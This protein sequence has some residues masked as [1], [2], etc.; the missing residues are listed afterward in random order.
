MRTR[1]LDQVVGAFLAETR[2]QGPRQIISLGA[3]TDTRPFRA[4]EWPHTDDLIYH[5]L[6]FAETCRRKLHIVRSAPAMARQLED[7]EAAES[8]SWS[9][10]PAKGPSEYHCHAGDLRDMPDRFAAAAGGMPASMRTDVPTLVLSECCLCYLTQRDSERVLSVFRDR[11]PRL[12]VVIYEPMPLDDAFGQVMV[13]NLRARSISMP[14]LERYR[15]VAGQEDRLRDAGFHAVGHATIKDAWERWVGGDERRRVDALEGLDE[16]EE[17][18]L[19]AAHYVVVWGT[20]GGTW[21]A[22]LGQEAR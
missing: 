5:E 6:D 13:S 15:D 21:L 19:L 12:A 18:Q 3:G 22:G 1:A 4:L 8:G 16:V 20:K 17:W 14:S 9:A 7:V 2:G 10:R 11:M